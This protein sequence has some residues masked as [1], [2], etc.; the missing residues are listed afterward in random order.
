M[1][2]KKIV[3]GCVIA[4]CSFMAGIVLG[5]LTHKPAE[6]Q[7]ETCYQL[8]NGTTRYN[9][10][11]FSSF[12]TANKVLCEMKN[13]VEIYGWACIADLCDLIGIQPSYIDN[14]YG[15]CN[16]DAAYIHRVKDGY[17]ICFPMDYALNN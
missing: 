11:R 14:K 10:M 5:D 4:A 1:K 12:D 6:A 2:M 8:H 7:K 16:L 3:G 17:K 13:V 9:N 15:W